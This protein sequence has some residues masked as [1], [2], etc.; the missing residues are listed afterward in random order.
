MPFRSRSLSGSL[1]EPAKQTIE[2]VDKRCR[3]LVELNVQESCINLFANPIVQKK[4]A[5]CAMPKIHG[6]AYDVENGLLRELKIDF[7]V[8]CRR[9]YLHVVGCVHSVSSVVF[10]SHGRKV[11]RVC[12]ECLSSCLI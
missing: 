11:P 1:P 6:W 12:C 5:T 10:P 3:R 8:H 7:K 2:D 4:Q 9:L